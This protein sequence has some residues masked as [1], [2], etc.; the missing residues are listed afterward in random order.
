MGRSVPLALVLAAVLVLAGCSGF[1]GGD[2]GVGSGTE[3]GVGIA[4]GGSDGIAGESGATVTPAPVPTVEGTDRSGPRLAPGLT[5]GGISDPDALLT[6]HQSVLDANSYTVRSVAR[7]TYQN[8]TTY[9]RSAATTRV[10]ERRERYYYVG[11]FT[12]ANADEDEDED[13]LAR[14]ESW[15]NG[16]VIL[17]ASVTRENATA[18]GTVIEN[19]TAGGRT[20]SDANPG[21]DE[22]LSAAGN[23]TYER[24]P[25][26]YE[27]NAG[28]YGPPRYGERIYEQVSAA[29]T[30]VRDRTDTAGPAYYV[31]A[32]TAFDES[33]AFD[34]GR[35]RD[36]RNA[37]GRLLVSPEGLVREYGLR[38]TATTPNGDTVR[39]TERIAYSKIGRTSVTRPAW[40]DEATNATG[41]TTT[42]TGGT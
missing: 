29:G 8:G 27:R 11:R 33:A 14:Y 10:T 18:G 4:N 36:V 1:S 22:G 25:A 12:L 38:Y 2:S 3:T 28:I 40:Y 15:S 24:V 30:T 17:T 16:R 26:E 23:A 35:F 34:G 6:A 42:S 7:A 32:L 31:V 37:S 39:V 13:A 20:T 41:E 19:E 5:T 21:I 9:Y